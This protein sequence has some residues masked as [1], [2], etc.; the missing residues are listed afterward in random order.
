MRFTRN[1][2]AI[3]MD[4]ARSSSV[5]VRALGGADTLTVG[6]LAG[7]GVRAVNV[8]LSGVRRQRRRR[9]PTT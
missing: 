8:D 2:A 6:D 7:T 5:N 1:V 9:Q 3:V 4:L